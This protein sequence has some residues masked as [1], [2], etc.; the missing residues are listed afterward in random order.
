MKIIERSKIDGDITSENGVLNSSYVVS[1]L[2]STTPRKKWISKCPEDRI[3]STLLSST[4]AFFLGNLKADAG[5]YRFLSQAIQITSISSANPALVTTSSNHGFET[6]DK[7]YFNDCAGSVDVN[8]SQYNITVISD[9]TFTIDGVDGST[10]EASHTASTGTVQ[11]VFNS[12]ELEL[13]QVLNYTQFFQGTIIQLNQ[14]WVDLD[15]SLTTQILQVNFHQS[16]DKK[17]DFIARYES[18]GSDDLGR[19]ETTSA[20]AV[21]LDTTVEVD[22]GSCVL[23]NE[24]TNTNIQRVYRVSSG[25]N[26]TVIL[27]TSSDPGPK[28]ENGDRVYFD[29]IGLGSVKSEVNYKCY[30]VTNRTATTFELSGTDKEFVTDL[31]TGVY[32]GAVGK[33][34]QIDRILGDGTSATNGIRF[35]EDPFSNANLDTPSPATRLNVYKIF[36]AVS[37]GILRAGFAITFPNA[38]WGYQDQKKSFSI[39]QELENGAIFTRNRNLVQTHN[40]QIQMTSDDFYRFKDFITT[41]DALPFATVILN[42]LDS[43]SR[44]AGYF[45]FLEQPSGTYTSNKVRSYQFSLR[46]FI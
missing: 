32:T 22:T 29:D 41:Q 31:G 17:G 13:R 25:S 6:G 27:N 46:E 10:F 38:Q 37:C 45:I 35:A 39:R 44:H 36:D 33:V 24:A 18:T 7:V 28:F 1:N 30:T 11:K 19:F 2:L 43:N 12:G 3:E 42:D 34:H 26:I 16:F 4:S 5:D 14:F 15:Y 8:D 23:F 21:A 40:G 20:T 9:T